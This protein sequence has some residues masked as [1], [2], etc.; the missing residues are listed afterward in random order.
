MTCLFT[1]ARQSKNDFPYPVNRWW[2]SWTHHAD[3]EITWQSAPRIRV[4]AWTP[5]CHL[6][7]L[8]NSIRRAASASWSGLM[9]QQGI[10]LHRRHA[11][12]TCL[13]AYLVLIFLNCV[14]SSVTDTRDRNR[15][16]FFTPFKREYSLY[17]DVKVNI[18]CLWHWGSQIMFSGFLWYIIAQII[19]DNVKFI[20]TYTRNLFKFNFL[21]FVKYKRKKLYCEKKAE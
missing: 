7:I 3:E 5:R 4:I 20:Y 19:T 18:V 12:S 11:F 6:K 21:K 14:S 9:W 13:T 8:F 15:G 1:R 2:R 17:R 10:S 16:L